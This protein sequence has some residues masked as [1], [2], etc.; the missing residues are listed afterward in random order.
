MDT[1]SSILKSFNLMTEQIHTLNCA[2]RLY[3]LRNEQI[4]VSL[5]N[6]KTWTDY[7]TTD[8]FLDENLDSIISSMT[9]NENYQIEVRLGT[10]SLFKVSITKSCYSALKKVLDSDETQD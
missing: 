9:D 10:E 4:I 3:P 1:K 7:L 8:E 6:A 2:Q 5:A